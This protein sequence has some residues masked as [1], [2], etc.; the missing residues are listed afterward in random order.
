MCLAQGHNALIPVRL[1]RAALR[2]S[3]KHSTTELP[4]FGL[5]VKEM[6][7]KDIK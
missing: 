3:V 4:E 5:M 7:L 1:E 2:S 6:L